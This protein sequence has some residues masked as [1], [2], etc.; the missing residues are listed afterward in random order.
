MVF[1]LLAQVLLGCFSA[2]NDRF[3]EYGCVSFDERDE[4]HLVMTPNDED[5]LAAVPLLIGML[6]C[7]QQ[8]ASFDMKDDLLEPDVPLSLERLVRGFIPGEIFHQDGVCAE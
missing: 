7:I 4:V 1:R 8:V 2:G 5:A 6:D 3:Q